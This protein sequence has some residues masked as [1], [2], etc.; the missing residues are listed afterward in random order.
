MV[1]SP[2]IGIALILLIPRLSNNAIRWISVLA[3]AIPLLLSVALIFLFDRDEAGIQFVERASWITSFNIYYYLG[4]DGLSVTMLLLTALL[5][6]LCVF[7]SWGIE[8]GV[9]GYFSMFLLLE[10]GMM[11]VFAALDFFLFYLFWEVMLLPMYFLIGVWGGPKKEFAAIKFF[12]YTLFGSVLMLVVMLAFYFYSVP[13]T[14]DLSELSTGILQFK[15]I[16]IFGISLTPEVFRRIL[17]IFLFIGFAIKVPIFPF[18]T[19]LPLAH[20]EAPTPISVLLAGILLK[21]GAYGLLRISFPILPEEAI[22]FAYPLA[23]FGLINVIYGAFCAMAQITLPASRGGNDWKKLIAYSSINHMGYVLL[24]MSV[25]TTEGMNGAVFQMFNHGTT[26]AMLF[27][28]VGVIY[29]RAHHRKID[30]FGGL[31]AQLPVYTGVV[32]LAF[33]ASLGL[34]GLSSFISEALVFLGAFKVYP[35]ITILATMGIVLNAAFF[36]WV[37]QKI[38]FGPLNSSYKDLKDLNWLEKVSLIPLSIIVVALGVYP[39]PVLNLMKASLDKLILLIQA[40]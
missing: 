4:T 19:W 11:G 16:E 28:L 25:F 22:W 15:N 31:G 23:F 14:F 10:T 29:D 7:A 39:M 40:T 37:F 13:H 6:F 26:T 2:L 36:L 24:G 8:K 20:V 3:A 9:K 32:A 27:L 35:T 33:F 12:L 5:S 21:M 38:F 17:Y 1:L 34:P 18:H 30:G